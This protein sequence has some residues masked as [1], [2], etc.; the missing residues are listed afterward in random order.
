MGKWKLEKEFHE[1]DECVLLLCVC[2][3]LTG[4]SAIAIACEVHV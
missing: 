3:C 1:M 2:V 4:E